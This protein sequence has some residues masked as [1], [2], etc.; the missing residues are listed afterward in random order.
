MIMVYMTRIL[1]KG[2]NMAKGELIGIINSD[3]NYE[4]DAVSNIAE[5]FDNDSSYDVYHG[6]LKYFNSNKLHM[7][8]G[9]SSDNLKKHMIE[10]PTCFVKKS[11][12]EELEGFD[13][14][15]ICCGL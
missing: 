11:V 9:S 10:H 2:I 7:I 4:L 15:R 5:V 13:C 3:D 6:L 14:N 1:N 12:Y 8:R